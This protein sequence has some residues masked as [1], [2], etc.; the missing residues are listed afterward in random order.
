[1]A[2]TRKETKKFSFPDSKGKLNDK[3]YS[4]CLFEL[5]IFD[6]LLLLLINKNIV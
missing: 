4:F 2:W 1:M 5:F 3:T 6:V